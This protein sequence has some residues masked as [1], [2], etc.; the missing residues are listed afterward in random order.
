M[1]TKEK[2]LK[3]QMTIMLAIVGIGI[4]WLFAVQFKTTP[5]RVLNPVTPYLSL[6]QAQATL[7][8]DQDETKNKI[9]ALKKEIDES[10][11][12]IKIQ[13][14][15][16][17][18]MVEELEQLKDK[19]G[20]T[21]KKGKG[22]VVTLADS[23]KEIPNIDSIVHAADLRDL[24]NVL[25]GAD[26]Q[27]ISVNDERLTNT[28]SIDSI[29]NT[30]LVDNTKITNPFVIR[31]EGDQKKIQKVLEDA[32]ALSDIKK[33]VKSEGLVFNT[34]KLDVTVNEFG[35]SFSVNFAKTK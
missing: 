4:G 19:V 24:V 7:T 11:A 30:I 28:S 34:E 25:W 20:L 35:A 12:Q 18:T 17:K 5:S 31:V 32:N 8:R 13:Q 1:F 9:K 2:R 23:S 22:V 10:Q 3:V 14:K 6:T 26:A 27:A 16:A 33:R 21:E 29:I 15:S